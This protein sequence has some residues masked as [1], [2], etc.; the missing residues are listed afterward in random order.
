MLRSNSGWRGGTPTLQVLSATA[1]ELGGEEVTA[2]MAADFRASGAA[3]FALEADVTRP[4]IVDAVESAPPGAV[5]DWT[6]EPQAGRTQRLAIRLSQGVSPAKPLRLV[7]TARR[8]FSPVL[9]KLGVDH[10]APLRFRGATDDKRLVAVRPAEPYALKLSGAERIERLAADN[11]SPTELG[12]FAEPPKDL[13][14]ECD[15][16]AGALRVS[17]IGREAKLSGTIHIDAAVGEGALRE[18]CRLRCLPQ[19]AGVERVLVQF[20]PRRQTAPRWTISGD[21]VSARKWSDRE[22]TKAGWDAS[23]ET[24]E[25]TLRHPKSTPFEITAVRE[26]S[27]AEAAPASAGSEPLCAD[28]GLFAGGNAADGKPGPA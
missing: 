23:L 13:L 3:R 25:L 22:Q 6:F 5:A 21:E 11:L 10:L 8:P 20:F 26:V 27:A 16:G 2:R 15:A 18:T 19:S 28:A 17:L 4:W 12:L 1:V 14:F 7:I 24:W 9:Q